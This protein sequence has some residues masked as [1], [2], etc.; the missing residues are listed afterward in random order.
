M[1]F[2]KA[3]DLARIALIAEVIFGGILNLT[4]IVGDIVAIATEEVRV[5][6]GADKLN[7]KIE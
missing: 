2:L 3:D 7:K 5:C 1:I 4:N 6:G